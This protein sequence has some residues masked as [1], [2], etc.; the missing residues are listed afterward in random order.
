MPRIEAVDATASWRER[1]E[2]VAALAKATDEVLPLIPLCFAR[3]NKQSGVI[4]ARK[5]LRG[6]IE[7]PADRAYIYDPFNG[8]VELARRA[9]FADDDQA[10]WAAGAPRRPMLCGP[11][12]R[13]RRRA[14]DEEGW[15]CFATRCS[16]RAA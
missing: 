12:T 14:P 7:T 15:P 4:L 5:S 1:E 9:W 8:Q 6:V 16:E 13:R 10:P 11:L 3:P 2:A